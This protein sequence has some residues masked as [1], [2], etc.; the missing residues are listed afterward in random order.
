MNP[1]FCLQGETEGVCAD[2]FV[3]CDPTRGNELCFDN[4][5]YVVPSE[6]AP[7]DPTAETVVD[8]A[9]E[10]TPAVAAI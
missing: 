5:D 3:A 4:P 7:A 8:P 6:E 10:S 1:K 9:A 2:P